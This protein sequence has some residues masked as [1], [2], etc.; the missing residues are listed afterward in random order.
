MDAETAVACFEVL[1]QQGGRREPEARGRLACLYA[2]RPGDARANLEKAAREAS[3]AAELGF[4]GAPITLNA[5]RARAVQTP[6]A[7]DLWMPPDARLA[8]ERA[9]GGA[10]PVYPAGVPRGCSSA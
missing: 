7:Q 5:L 6:G 3:R 8:E 4:A 9:P 2:E 1:A 10:E